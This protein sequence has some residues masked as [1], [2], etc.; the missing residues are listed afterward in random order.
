MRRF[1]VH[2]ETDLRVALLQPKP[3]STRLADRFWDR[4]RRRAMRL[5]G[6]LERLADRFEQPPRRIP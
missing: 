5:A 3:F 1:P 2:N 6:R 4:F